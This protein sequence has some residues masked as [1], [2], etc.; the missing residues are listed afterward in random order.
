VALRRNGIGSSTRVACLAGLTAERP[1]R[2][3]SLLGEILGDLASALRRPRDEVAEGWFSR[4]LDAALAPLLWLRATAGVALEA[5]QQN[6]LVAL[7]PMG[8]PAGAWYRDSQGWYVAAS[9]AGALRRLLPGFGDGV[10][11][12]FDD[13]LV[14]ER[15]EY[16]LGVNNVLGL[17]GAMG[18]QG[19]ADEEALLRRLRSALLGL[20]RRLR[21]APA[22]VESLLESPTLAC[23]ANL[24]HALDGKDELVG[25]VAAQSVYVRI[26][27]PLAEVG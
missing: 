11:A 10:E 5:H 27:N 21:P 9:R 19:L 8:W 3:A 16:Y 15:L 20:R 14:D 13:A 2:P 22:L 7:D 4:Y 23:K 17:I 25:S 6:T 12:I 1:D 18:A 26:A 24:L